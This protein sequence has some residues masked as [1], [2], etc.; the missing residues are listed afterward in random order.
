MPEMSGITRLFFTTEESGYFTEVV[1]EMFNQS[2]R[3]D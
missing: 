2:W 3:V 1:R